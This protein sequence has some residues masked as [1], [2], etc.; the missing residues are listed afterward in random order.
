M[1]LGDAILKAVYTT[2][3]ALECDSA[4]LYVDFVVGSTDQWTISERIYAC[5]PDKFIVDG[6]EPFEVVQL[7]SLC[8]PVSAGGVWV[9]FFAYRVQ[10][11]GAVI[12]GLLLTCLKIL[13][14]RSVAHTTGIS[15]C[16]VLAHTCCDCCKN[17]IDR[18]CVN[19]IPMHSKLGKTNND[20]TIVSQ[21]TL[22]TLPTI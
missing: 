21:R 16:H 11:I 14:W 5:D 17:Q 10:M 18:Q 13:R 22:L 2:S 12:V 1:V 7:N 3:D 15:R 9:H 6:S 20:R 8:Y 4:D 19:I